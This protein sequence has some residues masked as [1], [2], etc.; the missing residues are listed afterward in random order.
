MY[1]VTD[2]KDLC[3]SNFAQYECDVSLK[4]INKMSS[5]SL[6]AFRS[7][8]LTSLFAWLPWPNFNNK[9]SMKADEDWCLKAD[10]WNYIYK[11]YWISTFAFLV[12][13]SHKT[14]TIIVSFSWDVSCKLLIIITYGKIW[15]QSTQQTP[16][17]LKSNDLKKNCNWRPFNS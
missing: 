9:R 4:I 3:C 8:N 17:T 13:T 10:V 6:Y 16:L 5:L 11:K 7:C 12:D 2:N 1:S 14:N 15:Y